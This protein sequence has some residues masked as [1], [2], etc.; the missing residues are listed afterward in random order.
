MTNYE[1]HAQIGSGGMA[2]IFLATHRASDAFQRLVVLKR[3]ASHVRSSQEFVDAFLKEARISAA[4]SHPNIV[5]T[6]DYGE[7]T[8]GPF[9]V[10]EYLSGEPLSFVLDALTKRKS[11]LPL[12]LACGIAGALASGLDFVFRTRLPDGRPGQ[13][14]HRDVTPSNVMCCFNGQ[15]KL[16]DFGVAKIMNEDPH[17]GVLRGKAGYFSPEQI[18]QEP[19]DHRS[20]VFQLGIVFWEMLT[21]THL[22]SQEFP[23][24]LAQLAKGQIRT[25]REAAPDLPAELNDLAMWALDPDRERRCPSARAFFDHLQHVSPS[26]LVLE[27]PLQDF[28]SDNFP[29]R[30]RVR[31]DFEVEVRQSTI[32]S[33]ITDA[34]EPAPVVLHH[35]ATLTHREPEV[36]GASPRSTFPSSISLLFFGLVGI[37]PLVLIG[38]GLG[39][40]VSLPAPDP[41]AAEPI[42]KLH[43]KPVRLPVPPAP[44]PTPSLPPTVPTPL[45]SRA[46]EPSSPDGG[47]HRPSVVPAP[48]P[49]ND[50][51]S[52]PLPMQDSPP[53]TESPTV[54]Q[55]SEPQPVVPKVR[56]TGNLD[57]WN[58]L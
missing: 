13:I 54:E 9:L 22:F 52:P 6:L 21:G 11:R 12:T 19:L 41:D 26:A 28:M 33:R 29:E 42:R 51:P 10:L 1:I 16:L 46:P 35:T 40:I 53:P 44:L 5:T 23:K 32:A 18:R 25:P 4:M 45:S 14:V 3:I 47:S 57:P 38:L 20:D 27:S 36:D 39:L 8:D 2:E 30:R 55:S 7:D 37:V 49:T 56:P 15:L 17:S 31:E 43:T 24:A 58:S 48:E 50:P 34:S